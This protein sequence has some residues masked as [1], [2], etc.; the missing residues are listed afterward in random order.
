MASTTIQISEKT[1]SKLFAIINK[2][3]KKWGRRVTYDEAIELLIEERLIQVDKKDFLNNLKKFQGIL[4]PE[5]GTSLLKEL[6]RE[7]LE[8]EEKF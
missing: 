6:R 4:A 5:E 7:E 8:R 3:E 1:K 2:L